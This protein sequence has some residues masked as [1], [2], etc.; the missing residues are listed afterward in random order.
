MCCPLWWHQG[1]YITSR[2]CSHFVFI[3]G[4]SPRSWWGDPYPAPSS[5]MDL[6]TLVFTCCYILAKVHM[7][8]HISKRNHAYNPITG[9]RDL[10]PMTC[11]YSLIQWGELPRENLFLCADCLSSTG[12]ISFYLT[13]QEA[14]AVFTPEMAESG[15]RHFIGSK[16]KSRTS[17]NCC[18]LWHNLKTSKKIYFRGYVTNEIL[19]DNPLSFLQYYSS[20]H[21]K[22]DPFIN[23]QKMIVIHKKYRCN[24]VIWSV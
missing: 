15:K 24:S 10:I 5:S 4:F 8:L 22:I 13:Y 9:Y 14:T 20:L 2:W 18:L 17:K 6:A 7:L 1:A 21:V 23:S 19:H 12:P 16:W 11:S 3:S